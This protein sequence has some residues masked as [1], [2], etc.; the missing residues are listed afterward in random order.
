MGKEALAL[1]K[2]EEYTL[3]YP[4]KYGDFNV[5]Q[6][7]SIHQCCNDLQNILE[8]VL[9][10]YLRLHKKNYEHFNVILIIPDMFVK[11]HL[12]YMVSMI[13]GKMRFKSIFLHTESVMATYAMALPSACVVD[14][15]SSKVNVCCI[16]EGVVVTK[17]IIRKHYG[18]DDINEIFY[19]LLNKNKALHYFPKGV[20]DLDYHYHKLLLET[21]KE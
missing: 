4:I 15:G 16:D 12:K 7:Y 2:S 8:V 18:G 10:K 21:I 14:I 5:S 9:W 6:N 11:H 20:L 3:R 13:L 19:R 17:S 1:H